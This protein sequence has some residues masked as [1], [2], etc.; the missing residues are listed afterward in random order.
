MM[1][2]TIRSI[3][4]RSNRTSTVIRESPK[5]PFSDSFEQRTGSS[6]AAHELTTA[7]VLV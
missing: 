2:A 7:T 4:R 1:Q 3:L 6:E 5:Q